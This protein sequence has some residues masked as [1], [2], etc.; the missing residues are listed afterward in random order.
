MVGFV[1]CL[2]VVGVVVGDGV[3]VGRF[4]TLV[5]L[6]MLCG[7]VCVCRVASTLVRVV[8]DVSGRCSSG[9]GV[10]ATP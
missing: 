2:G 10:V 5:G 3:S 8:T 7:L 4:Q 6:L 9:G 1:W